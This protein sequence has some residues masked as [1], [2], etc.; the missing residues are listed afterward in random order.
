MPNGNMRTTVRAAL[1][2]TALLL[3]FAAVL[4]SLAGPSA[5]A[6]KT[7]APEAVPMQSSLMAGFW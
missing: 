1:F 7:S 5:P 6:V 2:G 3:F 4:L